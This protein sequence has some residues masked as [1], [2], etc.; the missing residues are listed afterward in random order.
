MSADRSGM[1]ASRFL[2]AATACVVLLRFAAESRESNCNGSVRRM[3]GAVA[4]DFFDFGSGDV[5]FKF[6]LK[7]CFKLVRRCSA[8]VSRSGFGAANRCNLWSRRP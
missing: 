8:L 7:K 1:A 3:T 2:V 4:A 6:P 5:P